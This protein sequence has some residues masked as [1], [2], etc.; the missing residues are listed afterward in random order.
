MKR[1]DFEDWAN[2]KDAERKNM[3]IG[4]N[5]DYAKVD[6]CFYNF[7]RTAKI[8]EVLPQGNT[9]REQVGWM[10]VAMKF[11]RLENLGM[12]EATNESRNDTWADLM[13]YLDLL[14][15]MENET[16]I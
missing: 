7:E 9:P 1:S 13:N 3:R 6:N 2:K 4:K 15:G 16:T 12:R 14:R 5:Q 10:F 8:Y 11:A